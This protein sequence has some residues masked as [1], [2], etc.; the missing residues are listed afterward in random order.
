MEKGNKK[1]KI[2]EMIKKLYLLTLL[3]KMKRD[4]RRERQMLKLAKEIKALEKR[5]ASVL[6]KRER[7]WR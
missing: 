1:G 7:D 2:K 4:K 6:E 5:K 3:N